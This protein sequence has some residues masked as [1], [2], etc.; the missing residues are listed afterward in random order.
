MR[1]GGQGDD[2][3][4]SEEPTQPGGPPSVESAIRNFTIA[5]TELGVDCSES[6]RALSQLEGDER[7]RRLIDLAEKME[8]C[9]RLV[10]RAAG[11]VRAIGE[12]T[13]SF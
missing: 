2:E 10:G 5:I 1:I 13:S 7:R 8:E 3:L 4:G 6:A 12:I 9:T 11:V